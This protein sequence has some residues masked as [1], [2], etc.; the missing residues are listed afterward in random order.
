MIREVRVTVDIPGFRTESLVVVTS[1]FDETE[2]P[3][4]DLAA[5]YRRR[6][7]VEVHLRAIKTTMHLDVLRCQ[8]PDMVHQELW[9]GLLAYNLIRQSILQSALD[10]EVRPERLSFTA[11]MQFLASTW[12][13]AV[14]TPPPADA[15]TDPLIALRL[16]HGSSHLVGNRPNRIEPR[17]IKRRP[18]PHKLLNLPRAAARAKLVAKR[19][20]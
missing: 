4:D 18:K 20:A 10:S 9:A 3:R 8:T 19:A 12:L 11:T 14:V 6:W 5:L 15:A 1:L 17:A 7:L 13:T 16:T 2:I